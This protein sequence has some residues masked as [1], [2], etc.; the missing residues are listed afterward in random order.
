[1]SSHTPKFESVPVSEILETETWN[2][3]RSTEEL[4]NFVLNRHDLLADVDLGI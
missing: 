2:R 1:M 4:T 3:Q